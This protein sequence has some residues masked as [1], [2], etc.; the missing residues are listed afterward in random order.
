M[1]DDSNMRRAIKAL[2]SDTSGEGHFLEELSKSGT[3]KTPLTQ[4]SP[5]SE[6][7]LRNIGKNS[8]YIYILKVTQ[9]RKSAV[10]AK[11]HCLD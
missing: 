11:E 1:N 2:D 7:L 10:I 4:T 3:G 9:K 8:V 5:T 6:Y